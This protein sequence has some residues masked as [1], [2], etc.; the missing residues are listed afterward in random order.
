ML[1]LI[2]R[3][4]IKKKHKKIFQ[5]HLEVNLCTISKMLNFKKKFL[6]DCA[7]LNAR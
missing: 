3:K 4:S 5:K 2:T 7:M 1:A 6:L